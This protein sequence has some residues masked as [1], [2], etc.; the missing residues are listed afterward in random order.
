M[1]YSAKAGNDSQNDEYSG[2]SRCS[3]NCTLPK[4]LVATSFR[5]SLTKSHFDFYRKCIMINESS[6]KM[7]NNT[8]RQMH[9]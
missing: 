1:M 9:I 2:S 6:L 4:H 7:T 8:D 3:K 5:I